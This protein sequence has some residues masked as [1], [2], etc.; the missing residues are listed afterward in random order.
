MVLLTSL[1][2][3]IKMLDYYPMLCRHGMIQYD[4]FISHSIVYYRVKLIESKETK[5]TN[6][7]HIEVSIINRQVIFY[8]LTTNKVKSFCCTISK[9]IFTYISDDYNYKPKS[10]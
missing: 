6:T 10:K 4:V 3:T 5:K 2:F 9:L 7:N 1:A 8:H